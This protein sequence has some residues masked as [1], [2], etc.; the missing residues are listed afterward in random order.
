MSQEQPAG[1]QHEQAEADV[2]ER[3]K[4]IEQLLDPDHRLPDVDVYPLLGTTFSP[5]DLAHKIPEG[6]LLPVEEAT[7]ANRRVCVFLGVDGQIGGSIELTPENG[8]QDNTLSV[9]DVHVPERLR[10]QG[11]GKRLYV[12]T[13]KALPPGVEMTSHSNLKP[14]GQRMWGWLLE[15][16]LARPRDDFQPDGVAGAYITQLGSLHVG[17]KPDVLPV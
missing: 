8:L 15:H 10:G 13:L 11:Y 17:S 2:A 5:A 9:I 12:E 6:T 1:L 16:D 3:N 7:Q 14:D 4:K